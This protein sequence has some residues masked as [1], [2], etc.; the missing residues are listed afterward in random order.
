MIKLLFHRL[1]WGLYD[2]LGTLTISGLIAAAG[3]WLLGFLLVDAERLFLLVRIPSLRWIIGGLAGAWLIYSV[4]MLFSLGECIAHEK[5]IH[6]AAYLFPSMG[7]VKAAVMYTSFAGLGTL[8]V[9]SNIYFYA[10]QAS[11]LGKPWGFAS[12]VVVILFCYLMIFW[13]VYLM[14]LFGT[15]AVAPDRLGF[16]ASMRTALISLVV[17]PSLWISAFFFFA[18]ISAIGSL[19]VLGSIFI[20]PVWS[21]TS[22]IGIVLADEFLAKLRQAKSELGNGQPL[23]NYR[24][25]ACELMIEDE[26]RKPPRTWKDILKPWEY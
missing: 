22:S 4:A 14:P 24:R 1:F 23:K 18:M 2:Y 13:F 16:F 17:L 25:R 6:P 9:S 21:A 26:L 5:P 12:L 7:R 20:L 15:V 3:F 11:R 8:L 19:T 10:V